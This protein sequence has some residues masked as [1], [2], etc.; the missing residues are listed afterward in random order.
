MAWEDD[1]AVTARDPNIE[2]DVRAIV[3]R[4]VDGSVAVLVETVSANF[5]T[6]G[7]L[8]IAESEARTGRRAS[9]VLVPR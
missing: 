5:G 1:T 3:Q 2:K 6:G 9:T 7:E 8:T 4:I